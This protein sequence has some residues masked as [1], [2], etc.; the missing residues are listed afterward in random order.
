MDFTASIEYLAAIIVIVAAGALLGSGLRRRADNQVVQSERTKAYASLIG[1]I[2]ELRGASLEQKRR[3]AGAYRRTLLY[4]SDAVVR[5]LSQFVWTVGAP[6]AD[7]DPLAALEAR[8]EV[9]LA[10]RRDTQALLGAKTA[11]DADDLLS[12]EVDESPA[13]GAK[14]APAD[15]V[16]EADRD[17]SKNAA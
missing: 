8:D 16:S 5:S 14:I 13:T 12:V 7:Y 6:E 10:M 17:W 15:G 1:S 4:G 2:D 11:L 3:F 9:I